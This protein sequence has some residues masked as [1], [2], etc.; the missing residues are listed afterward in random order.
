MTVRIAVLVLAWLTC[1]TALC[2]ADHLVIKLYCLDIAQDEMASLQR[3]SRSGQFP[4]QFSLAMAM[5][6]LDQDKV[7]VV[8][9]SRLEAVVGKEASTSNTHKA[10]YLEL[11]PN[12]AWTQKLSDWDEGVSVSIIPTKDADG[13]I[14]IDGIYSLKAINSRA[15][16]VGVEK[17]DLGRPLT[18][19]T[20]TINPAVVLRAGE[21]RLIGAFGNAATDRDRV[22][23]VVVQPLGN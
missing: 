9:F 1:S 22:L 21:A 3:D 7:K 8:A 5:S 23:I 6:L 14:H 4:E 20:Q 17:W 19:A 10:A 12:G 15:P 2:A 11:A 13:R 16:L 18:H